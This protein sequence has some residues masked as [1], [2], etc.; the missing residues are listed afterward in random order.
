MLTLRTMAFYKGALSITILKQ[1]T[2]NS[3]RQLSATSV[4]L[5]WVMFFIDMLSVVRLTV[6][7]PLRR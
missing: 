5:L 4:V 2:D 6:V 1:T 7:A 3:S